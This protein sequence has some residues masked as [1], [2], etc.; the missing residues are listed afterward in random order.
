M[1]A[2]QCDVI[3]AKPFL[4]LCSLITNAVIELAFLSLDE[5]R[6]AQLTSQ[7]GE[8]GGGIYIRYFAKSNKLGV[9]HSNAKN[10]GAKS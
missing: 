3:F 10:R 4:P 8:K 1:D 9:I 5:L 2:K 7:Q 6:A